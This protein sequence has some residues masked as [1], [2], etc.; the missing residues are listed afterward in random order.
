LIAGFE[1]QGSAVQRVRIVVLGADQLEVAGLTSCFKASSGFVVLPAEQV[2]EAAVVVVTAD[3][4][5]SEVISSLRRVAQTT[6]API[7]LVAGDIAGDELLT[8]LECRV[9][10]VVPRASATVERLRYAAVAAATG[11]A[12]L[13]P[14]L[15]SELLQQ[16]TRL[17]QEVLA[18]RGLTRSGLTLRE[19]EILR[20]VADG[21][22][23]DEVAN[24]LYFST[25]TV[26]NT[27]H[28]MMSRLNLRNRQHAVAYALRT[29]MI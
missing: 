21:F 2:A 7:V 28:E 5:R 13:P 22:D 17:Q 19:V 23:Y 24:K 1:W 11:G 15:L 9:V 10:A 12:A 16:I 26:K 25:R 20:L 14:K 18:P 27:L 29:G 4:L 6:K 3:R 8:A